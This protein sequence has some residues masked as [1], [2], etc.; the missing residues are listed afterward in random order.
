MKVL[1]T[2][3]TGVVGH[4]VREAVRDR[5]DLDCVFQRREDCDLMD[6][7]ATKAYLAEVAPDAVIHLAARVYGIQGN[8][9]NKGL[10]YFDNCMIN[11]HVVE[12]ARLAGVKRFVA[13]GTGAVYPELAGGAPLSESDI[14]SG[15]PHG[16]EDSYAHAKRGMLAQLDAYRTQYG[17]DSAFVVSCN[18]FGP[19]DRFNVAEGH[20]TPSLI[21]KFEE[22]KRTG[23]KVGVWGNGSAVRDFLFSYD[24]GAAILAVLDSGVQ[25][26]VNFGCGDHIAIR[27]IVEE[28]TRI[29]GF[30]DDRIAWD[31]SK[32]NG[33]AK[34]VYDLTRLNSTGF[35]ARYSLGE[36]LKITA[37]WYAAHRLEART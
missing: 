31:A 12:A 6:F 26:P 27:T 28:L 15:P 34:R 16:S 5:S 10:S 24:C 17:F 33:Q 23:G 18:I 35:K 1:V 2:G 9:N 13:M 19:H 7:A 25:G 8:L 3:S 21:A 29:Y 14:W 32:P 30:A 22:A 20:V 36:G 11:T 37:D 4:G